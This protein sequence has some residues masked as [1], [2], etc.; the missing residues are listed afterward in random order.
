MISHWPSASPTTV[1][2]E[3]IYFRYPNRFK[4]R[5]SIYRPSSWRSHHTN[6]WV[7]QDISFAISEGS[8]TAFI[9]SNGTGKTTLMRLISGILAPD[10]GQITTT[11]QLG[12]FLDAGYGLEEDLSGWQN[13]EAYF[14]AQKVPHAE[15]HEL[16]SRTKA[17]SGLGDAFDRPIRTYS[18][19]MKT[20]L[21]F[22]M[23]TQLS[24]RILVID[25]GFGMADE[26]FQRR[27]WR[28]IDDLVDNAGIVIVA[29]HSESFIRRFCDSA[30]LLQE[31]AVSEK[32]SLDDAFHMYRASQKS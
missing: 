5:A 9:G 1:Q 11:G 28:R 14:V 25:E 21:V 32:L 10:A 20:R 3:G 4:D 27:A 12:H 16:C 15:R 17:F 22:S 7:F 6:P 2:V 31:C 13:T 30:H 24:P 19:G 18:S 23:T 29:S 8:K 26:T